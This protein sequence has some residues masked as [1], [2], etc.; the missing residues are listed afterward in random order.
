LRRLGLLVAQVRTAADGTYRFADLSADTYSLEIANGKGAVI[1]G[2]VLDGQGEY[3]GD[4]LWALPALRSTVQGHVYASDGAAVAGVTVRLLRDGVEVARTQ[5]DSAGAFQFTGLPVG[6][7]ALAVGVGDPLIT[8]IQVGEGVTIT[9]DVS[10]PPLPGKLFA[11]YFLFARAAA[12]VSVDAE[13][14]LALSLAADYLL[15]SSASGGFNPDEAAKAAQVMIVGSSVPTSV[16]ETLRAAG[17]QVERL[18]G[19]GFALAEAFA[20]LLAALKGG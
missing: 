11:R 13:Q 10:L 2:I 16:E 5:S 9:Q 20:R 7:Y 18:P 17:C 6:V 15:C 4:F 8:G 14:R 12:G 19:D 1:N 3:I